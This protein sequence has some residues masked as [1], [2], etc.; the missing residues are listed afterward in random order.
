ME[1]WMI[2]PLDC[3][4]LTHKLTL[5]LSLKKI[6]PQTGHFFDTHPIFVHEVPQILCAIPCKLQHLDMINIDQYQTSFHFSLWISFAFHIHLLVLS[7]MSCRLS[8]A[9]NAAF[10][11]PRQPWPERV[12]ARNLTAMAVSGVSGPVDLDRIFS[13][14]DVNI[15]NGSA[16]AFQR[17]ELDWS[18]IYPV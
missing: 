2:H 4:K 10:S 9:F 11:A 16:S 12:E 1:T 14:M 13:L 6:G 18:L 15:V 7:V 17:A 5:F 3:D 8:H